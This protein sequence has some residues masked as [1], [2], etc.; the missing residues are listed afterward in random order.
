MWL[1][2]VHPRWFQA[3]LAGCRKLQETFS[4]IEEEKRTL[5]VYLCEDPSKLALQDVFS[6]LQTFRE[7]FIKACKVS[8]P[9]A[10]QRRQSDH[11]TAN[12]RADLNCSQSKS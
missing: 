12:Q 4:S 5:A 3:N 7:L 6:T 1:Y 10:S 9:S 2:L 8:Y 11:F